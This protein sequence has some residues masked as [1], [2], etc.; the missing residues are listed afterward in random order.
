MRCS[1][2][3]NPFGALLDKLPLPLVISLAQAKERLDSTI[4]RI[5]NERRA[6]G[7]DRG[8]LL[9]MLLLAQDEEGDGGSMTNEQLRDER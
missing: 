8:D 3:T 6:A 2:D 9:S 1:S 5:I 4:Y 7:V